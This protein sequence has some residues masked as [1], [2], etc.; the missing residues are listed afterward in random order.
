MKTALEAG[1]EKEIQQKEE[2]FSE[3]LKFLGEGCSINPKTGRPWGST[4][5]IRHR[6]LDKAR[7]LL[8]L[9]G[10]ITSLRERLET[11]RITKAQIKN[12]ITG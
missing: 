9:N 3:T 2:A 12:E 4:M 7:E 10:A 6:I 1:L 11:V 5:E 8:S